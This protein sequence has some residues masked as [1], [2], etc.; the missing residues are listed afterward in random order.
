MVQQEKLLFEALLFEPVKL[1]ND[2]AKEIVDLQK[3]VLVQLCKTHWCPDAI[4]LWA[5]GDF[6]RVELIHSRTLFAP[7]TMTQSFR[8]EAKM[9]C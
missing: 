4:E 1:Q 3:G 6:G 8:I 5:H 2:V 7:L 9:S